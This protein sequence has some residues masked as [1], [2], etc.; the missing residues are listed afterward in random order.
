M[1]TDLR[2][3]L[4]LLVKS[5]WFTS[6]TVLVLA[7]GLAISI[8]TYAALSMMVYRDLPL[9]DGGSIVRVGYGDWVN[10]EPLD[11][12]ELAELRAQA[13]SIDELGVY[14]ESRALVG[15]SGAS[16]SVLSVE[17]DWRIFEFTRI[18]PL[19]GRGFVSD[20][21]AAGA[22]PVAVLG[23]ATWQSAF[24]GDPSIVGTLARIN[25]QL[26]RI[27]G[28]MPEGYAFPTNK[29]I[30][31]P[32]PASEVEPTSYS[33]NKLDAYARVRPGVSVEA[34]ETDLTALVHRLRLAQPDADERALDAVEILSFQEESW[35]ALGHVIF[36]VL[37][38]LSLSILLLAAVNI[39]NLLLA[40]TN[41]RMNEIGVRV[42]LGAPRLRLIVQTA[43]ENVILC[44]L[45]GALAVFLA[46]K[47]LEATSGFMRALLG[48]NMPFWWTWSLDGQVVAVAVV[49][50]A[51]TVVVVS[52]LPA[53][54]VMRAD[55]NALLKDG[56]RAG[57]GLETGRISRALVTVQV[58]LISAVMLVGT[59]VTLIA[60][61]TADFDWGMD[62]ANLYMMGI[63]LPEDR[64]ATVAEQSSFYDRLLAE[65]RATPGVDAAR[66]MQES[67]AAPFATEGAEYATPRDRPAAWLVVLSES[68]TPI[69]PTLIEGRT[70]DSSDNATGL[71]TALVSRNLAREQWP[72]KPPLGE[73]IDI[74]IG[75][76]ATEQRVIVGV[77]GDIAFDPVG[78]TAAG[79]SA[80]YVPL[81]QRILPRSRAIVRHFGEDAAV[82]S[83]LYEALARIDPTIAPNIQT[84]D[85]A[86]GQITLFSR[87]MT[88]LF[89]GC[90]AFAILL[91][92]TGIYG[93]S[94]NAVVLRTHEIGLRRALGATNG[95]VIGL[96]VRQSARQLTI[97][98]SL[99]ALLSVAVLVVIRQ[100]FSIGAGEIALIGATV[101]LVVAATVLL[102]VYLSVQSA[103]R[104]DPSSALR[105]G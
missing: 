19:L 65:L 3:A 37:N 64:Y 42:A 25:G 92:I 15:E 22:E 70:F 54:S 87:T 96:F 79:N 55:P 75:G 6:L 7:G 14:R 61:R 44:A 2:Y 38:L 104:L 62:T 29:G 46:V 10:F 85:T 60:G 53:F 20:D 94:S 47:A 18:P 91:A 59:A 98:L 69:G 43:L 73:T 40:R 74:G 83:A 103:I 89:A 101:V 12:F 17:S 27:V 26:T 71:K 63:E 77:V 35:G 51:L 21:G 90:G 80:I 41:A 1:I 32:L 8:Y 50:L 93:M 95:S 4:R 99:S 49:L 39:G 57:R 66:I 88:K 100:G 78:M 84:Y 102:S 34:A 58:A 48:N 9:P 81:P 30:W 105:Q 36:G 52:V 76:S 33:G 16:R 86:I 67:G 97:G 5:P 24:A 28:V 45:G 72:D 23:Y 13:Q 11:T 68:P 56:A 31:L 82:R